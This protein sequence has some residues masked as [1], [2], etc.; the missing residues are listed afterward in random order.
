MPSGQVIC[1][2]CDKVLANGTPRIVL[3]IG[4]VCG[5]CA[6]YLETDKHNPNKKLKRVG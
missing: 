4:Y 1:V 5:D 6:Y 3:P 2:E